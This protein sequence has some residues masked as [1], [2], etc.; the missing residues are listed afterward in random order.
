M[1]ILEDKE[2][3]TQKESTQVIKKESEIISEISDVIEDHGNEEILDFMGVE[4]LFDEEN[5]I[6]ELVDINYEVDDLVEG[7]DTVKTDTVVNV[8]QSTQKCGDVEIIGGA[9]Y[10]FVI[11]ENFISDMD[12]L[13][14]GTLN[15]E[16]VDMFEFF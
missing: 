12:E 1:G 4:N 16:W 15:E 10:D 8:N 5:Q 3:V 13:T 14:Y 7:C 2:F 11:F 9:N 6:I